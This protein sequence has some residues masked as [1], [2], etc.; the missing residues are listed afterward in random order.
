MEVYLIPIAVCGIIGL[1]FA[2]LLS[3]ASKVFEVK[4]DP[5]VDK[6]LSA[7][8]G[9]NC[10]ACGFPGCEGCANAIAKGDAPVTACPVGGATCANKIAEILGVDAG[11][12]EKMVACVL[13]Q[14]DCDKTKIKYDYKGIESC[15]FASQISGGP[16]SCEFGCVGCA[17]CVKACP[18]DAIEMRNGVAFVL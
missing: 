4:L 5:T 1:I 17:S 9:A 6:V 7:L 2:V 3:I 8:P 15:S 14:G 10:G 12:T 13:C 16:K 18:F 11:S